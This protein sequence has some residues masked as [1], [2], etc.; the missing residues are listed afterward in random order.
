MPPTPSAV[1]VR[2]A[3][4]RDPVVEVIDAAFGEDG[5]VGRLWADVTDVRA[6]L[7]AELESRVVGH[8]GASLCWIDARARLVEAWMLS[9]LSV[10]PEA[11]GRGIGTALVA[12]LLAAAADAGA[13]AVFLEGA[14]AYYGARGF[15]RASAY[16]FGRYTDRVPDAAFQVALLDADEPW[17]RGRVVVP[18]VWW[19]HDRVGLRD[20]VL[21]E[22]EARLD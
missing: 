9:P 18:D 17:M 13:P 14:P 1:L 20:P 5:A 6:S 15:A 19:R 11:Q 2:S 12:A 16:G 4:A 3:T 21:A 8:V 10:R 22:I 7:V